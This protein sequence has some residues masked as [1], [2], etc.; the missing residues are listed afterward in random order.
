MGL[1]FTLFENMLRKGDDI[2]SIVFRVHHSDVQDMPPN[3]ETILLENPEASGPFGA[4]GIGEVSVV[5]PPQ[6]SQMQFTRQ[7]AYGRMPSDRARDP[8]Q[9]I[10]H[11]LKKWRNWGAGPGSLSQT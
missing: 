5:P 7:P 11:P 10:A 1:G 6:R 9:A 3:L 8:D 4:K 2:G